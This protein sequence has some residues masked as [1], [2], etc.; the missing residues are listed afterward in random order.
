MDCFAALAMTAPHT[1][2]RPAAQCARAF[3]RTVRPERTEGAGNAG[4][5]M[6]PIAAC[7]GVVVESTRVRQV[8]PESP[9]IPYAMVLT[10]YVV[11]SPVIGLVCHRHPANMVLSARSGSQNLRWT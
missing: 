4:R 10:A 9:G 6:R 8:T 7:A 1:R 5:P 11:L 2:Q 3:D